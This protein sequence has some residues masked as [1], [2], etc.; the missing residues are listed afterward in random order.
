[1]VKTD[2]LLIDGALVSQR[3][4]PVKWQ[5]L[6]DKSERTSALDKGSQR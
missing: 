1:M 6:R 3:F 4:T 5:L 2:D